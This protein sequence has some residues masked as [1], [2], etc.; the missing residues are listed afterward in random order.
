MDTT[1]HTMQYIMLNVRNRGRFATTTKKYIEA[2]QREKEYMVDDIIPQNS[3]K[4]GYKNGR[5][6]QAYLLQVYI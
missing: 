5:K 2:M 4:Q 6:R 3:I 1:R